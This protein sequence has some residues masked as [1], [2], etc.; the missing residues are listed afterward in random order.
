MLIGLLKIEIETKHTHI[1]LSLSF[2]R[3]RAFTQSNTYVDIYAV[4]FWL[5]I[6]TDD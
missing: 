5:K 1:L 6:S 4:E 3:I 2:D